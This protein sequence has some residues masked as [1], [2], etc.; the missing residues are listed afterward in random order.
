MEKKILTCVV[1]PN[2]CELEVSVDSD[3]KVLVSGEM[4]PRAIP[5]AEQELINPER[6]IA[7]SILVNGGDWALVSVRT[8]KSI[9]LEKILPAMEEIKAVTLEAPISL[10]DILIP[11][12]AGTDAAIIATRNILLC[13]NK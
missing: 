3:N 9:P 4:C 13:E 1:C 12:I 7:S 2:G 5:W 11:N 8:D 6:T 10:G